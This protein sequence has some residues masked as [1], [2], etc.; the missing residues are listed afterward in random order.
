M[1]DTHFQSSDSDSELSS[2]PSTTEIV[3]R[4]TRNTKKPSIKI[5]AQTKETVAIDPPD[6]QSK[7]T[8]TKRKAVALKTP[9]L[10]RKKKAK[11]DKTSTTTQSLSS[12]TSISSLSEGFDFDMSK[13]QEKMMGHSEDTTV[14]LHAI[15]KSKKQLASEMVWTILSLTY[16]WPNVPHE[17]QSRVQSAARVMAR[18][19]DRGLIDDVF[20]GENEGL[21]YEMVI[22]VGK[23]TLNLLERHAT[24]PEW[25]QHNITQFYNGFYLGVLA[26]DSDK[27]AAGMKVRRFIMNCSNEAV[28]EAY[29]N[30]VEQFT[31]SLHDPIGIYLHGLKATGQQSH[32]SDEV[33]TRLDEAWNHITEVEKQSRKQKEAHAKS[34]ESAKVSHLRTLET[35]KANYSKKVTEFKA[36]YQGDMNDLKAE[37]EELRTVNEE[38]R[39]NIKAEQ[40]LRDKADLEHGIALDRERQRHRDEL[41][42]RERQWSKELAECEH[43]ADDQV[44]EANGYLERAEVEVERLKSK[45]IH[46]QILLDDMREERDDQAKKSAS[47]SLFFAARQNEIDKRTQKLV[48]WEARLAEQQRHIDSVQSAV[49]YGHQ[50]DDTKSTSNVSGRLT[51]RIGGSEEGEVGG[52]NKSQETYMEEHPRGLNGEGT[53]EASSNATDEV[54]EQF[55]RGSEQSTQQQVGDTDMADDADTTIG[56]PVS[57][58]SSDHDSAFNIPD[59][60]AAPAMMFATAVANHSHIGNA[61][62]SDPATRPISSV[63]THSVPPNTNFDGADYEDETMG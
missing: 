56:A 24:R 7:T 20:K 16:E 46:N 39:H 53:Q 47:T 9:D 33:K 52:T 35:A 31:R 30:V 50:Q 40:K 61:A 13:L 49:V 32:I 44:E 11:V 21:F 60:A 27:A 23:S 2:A 15:Q 25:G 43:K 26:D 6:T 37:N 59:T 22:L 3:S 1:T 8:S 51:N 42:N 38:L 63:P 19:I 28:E 55:A 41:F 14:S 58:Q 18:L 36:K 12:S 17:F 45:C 4:Q 48:N 54:T 10:P 34:L 5:R 57:A 62:P 29:G